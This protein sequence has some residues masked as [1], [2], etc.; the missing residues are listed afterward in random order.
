MLD[1]MASRLDPIPAGILPASSTTWHQGLLAARHAAETAD[2]DLRRATRLID[3]R[4]AEPLDLAA[5]ARAAFLS[6]AHFHRSYTHAFGETPH[7]ALTRRRIDAARALLES[8]DRSVTEICLMV[9]FASL[10]SFS[11]LFRRHVGV[12]P[13]HYRRRMFA[14]AELRRRPGAVPGCFAQRFGGVVVQ[15]TRRSDTRTS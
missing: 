14:V 6:R 4:Y 11:T 8:T 3:E 1:G 15:S 10:G 7:D 13:S 9:R 12:P 2:A 5:L